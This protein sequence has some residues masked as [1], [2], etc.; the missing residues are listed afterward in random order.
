MPDLLDPNFHR[1][2]VLIVHHDEEGTVGM[3]LNRPTEVRAAELCETLGVTWQGR[4]EHLVHWGGP[5]QPNTGWV[6]SDSATLAAD[7]AATPLLHDLHFAGTLDA[8]RSVA[9]SPTGSLRLFLG[10]AGWGPGQLEAE[11]AQGAWVVAPLEDE[12]ALLDVPEGELWGHIWT[13]LGVDP[14][15]I[16]ATPGV[17]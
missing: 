5:V 7:P 14:A 3:V 2:V 10:Y 8:L 12:E 15:T 1:T 6:V 9:Q 4:G 11:L 16:V 13:R 17:H